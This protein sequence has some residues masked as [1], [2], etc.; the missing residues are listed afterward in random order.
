MRFYIKPD[1][2]YN[3]WRPVTDTGVLYKGS[4]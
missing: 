2:N 3:S 4:I 1:I